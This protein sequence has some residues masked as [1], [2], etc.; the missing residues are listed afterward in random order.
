MSLNLFGDIIT[1]G[2]IMTNL[3]SYI[4]K[5]LEKTKVSPLK[6][7]FNPSKTRFRHRKRR[8][9]GGCPAII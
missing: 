7:T 1:I 9:G 2:F 8:F 4:L 6:M 3:N 5:C